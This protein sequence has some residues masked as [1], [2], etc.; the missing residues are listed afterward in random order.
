MIR[1]DGKGNIQYTRGDDEVITVDLVVMPG[2]TKRSLAS[3]ERLVMTV[4]RPYRG[5]TYESFGNVLF[6]TTAVGPA[7][8]PALS[9]QHSSTNNADYGRYVYDI[10]LQKTSGSNIVSRT[11]VVGGDKEAPLEFYIVPEVTV[12]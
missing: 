3:N 6:T 4:R 9:I 1:V 10:E 8:R 12:S 5:V 11:T 2:M 7:D